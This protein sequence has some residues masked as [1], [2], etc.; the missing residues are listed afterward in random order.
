MQAGPRRHERTCPGLFH[1]FAHGRPIDLNPAIRQAL[2]RATAD[3]V[4]RH[5]M[6]DDG[7]LIIASVGL[8]QCR[9]DGLGIQQEGDV[10][11]RSID[12]VSAGDDQLKGQLVG[13]AGDDE[14]DFRRVRAVESNFRPLGLNPKIPECFADRPAPGEPDP[15][16][17]GRR[18][19]DGR[20]GSH[21]DERARGRPLGDA[22][23]G[24]AR[25]I[26]EGLGGG[27]VVTPGRSHHSVVRPLPS[28]LGP[29]S[30]CRRVSLHPAKQS[31]PQPKCRTGTEGGRGRYRGERFAVGRRGRRRIGRVRGDQARRGLTA[32]GRTA[33]Q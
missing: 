15:Q 16:A 9:Q 33:R 20:G 24:G 1:R 3:G 13:L 10:H 28:A 22:K 5:A 2:P 27:S 12:A 4:E 25:R 30:G 31:E 6:A 11:G 18:P 26:R 23:L 7:H 19:R 8:D 21:R 17:G 32:H 29:R 14:R